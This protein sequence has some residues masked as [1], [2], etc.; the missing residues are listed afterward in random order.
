[1]TIK[2]TIEN[3]DVRVPE[4]N[5]IPRFETPE[6]L[7]AWMQEN[8]TY[9]YMDKHY[10]KQ[11]SFGKVWWDTFSLLLPKEVFQYRTGT[12]FDQTIFEQYIFKRDFPSYQTRMIFIAA[13][14]R[15]EEA[16][17]HTFLVYRTKEGWFWFENAFKDKKGIHGPYTNVIEIVNDVKKS[18]LQFSPQI[19]KKLPVDFWYTVMNPNRFTR[20]LSVSGFYN[21]V[22]YPYMRGTDE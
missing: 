14:E 16:D 20:K 1:M 17:T 4:A 15:G 9:G 6:A 18:M 3:K 22:E 11:R 8:L 2:Y 19:K 21:A 10:K 7:S 5:E 13:F 12:C